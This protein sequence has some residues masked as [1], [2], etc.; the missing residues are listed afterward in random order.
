MAISELSLNNAI[1][2][3]DDRR[4]ESTSRREQQNNET[5]RS[6]GADS[7]SISSQARELQAQ[8]NSAAGETNPTVDRAPDSIEQP[9]SVEIQL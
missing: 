7:V 8:E 6:P 2:R 9:Q 3:L 1:P 4:T 5:P